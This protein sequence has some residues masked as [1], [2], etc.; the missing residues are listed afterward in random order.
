MLIC[1]RTLLLC[2]FVG[3]QEAVS[4]FRLQARDNIIGAGNNLSD[5]HDI[6]YSTTITLNGRPVS[7]DTRF[8]CWLSPNIFIRSLTF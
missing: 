4:A 5:S 2:L 7:T 3:L 6:R 1:R 8:E